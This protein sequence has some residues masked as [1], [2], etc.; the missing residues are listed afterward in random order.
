MHL[1]A[2]VNLTLGLGM[3]VL[4]LLAALLQTWLWTFPMAPDPSGKDPNGVTTAPKFWRMMHRGLGYLYAAIYL[5]LASQ[6]L[7]RLW[8]FE[9]VAWNSSSVLHALFG[10]SIGFVL[11]VKVWILRRAQRFGKKLP[12]LGWS[13]VGLTL[14]TMGLASRPVV[15][16]MQ[17]IPNQ[18][19]SVQEAKAAQ[20]RVLKNCTQCH[21]LSVVARGDDNWMEIL[22]DMADN[23][24]D[25]GLPDPS[26]G[27]RLQTAQYLTSVFGD[28]E[29]DERDDDSQGRGR[30]RGRSGREDR[31]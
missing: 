5:V 20:A 25:R 23:A 11:G 19:L 17:P 13:L 28:S 15:R 14:L 31:D 10:L 22:E 12:Y 4:G 3:L 7:P 26:E 8:N 2:D 1:S 16:V 6:M 18:V 29:L 9:S 24:E 21:G 27:R 30:G